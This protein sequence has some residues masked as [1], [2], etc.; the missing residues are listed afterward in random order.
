MKSRQAR[1]LGVSPMPAVSD[2][3]EYLSP[4][5]SSRKKPHS[6]QT[7]LFGISQSGT[8]Y[9]VAQL[10]Q[11][12]PAGAPLDPVERAAVFLGE[13]GVDV[14]QLPRPRPEPL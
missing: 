12:S 13:V 14:A 3:G 6:A 1:C 10:G 11:R 7:L 9:S 8:R 4:S 2:G 5:T